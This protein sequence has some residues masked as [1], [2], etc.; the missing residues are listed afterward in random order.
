MATILV[1]DDDDHICQVIEYALRKESHSV[2]VAHE[3]VA[4]LGLFDL[5][6]PDIVL[7]DIVMPGMDGLELCRVMRN[8]RDVPIVFISSKDEEI[9]KIVGLEV[10]GDDYVTKPFSPRELAARVRAVL[11]RAMRP[12]APEAQKVIRYGDLELDLS[13]C[14]GMFS[15]RELALTATEYRVLQVL[16]RAPSKVFSR[17]ELMT[18]ALGEDSVVSDRTIDSHI[19]RVRKKFEALGVDPIETVHGF[20]YR[21]GQCRRK[22]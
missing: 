8:R 13:G 3:A 4:A 2:A 21:I 15:G 6:R 17:D 10:G 1:V 9:D 7:L 14:R 12:P 18:G 16:M 19:K 22:A 5:V 11:R 20:G